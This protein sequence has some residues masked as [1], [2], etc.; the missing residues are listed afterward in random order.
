MCLVSASDSIHLS[1]QK[2]KKNQ[3]NPNMIW[4]VAVKYDRLDESTQS[5]QRQRSLRAAGLTNADDDCSSPYAHHQFPLQTSSG[6]ARRGTWAYGVQLLTIVGGS[7]KNINIKK[8]KYIK[9]MKENICLSTCLYTHIHKHT[10]IHAHWTWEQ[11]NTTIT[12]EP[13]DES[14]A[15]S[16]GLP[17]VKTVCAMIMTDLWLVIVIGG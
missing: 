9:K 8:S 6:L 15:L 17:G 12:P 5:V 7:S 10:H 16:S 4:N 14:A 11:M 1:E 2:K 13:A 3:S